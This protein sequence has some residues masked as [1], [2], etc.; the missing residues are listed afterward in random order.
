MV[1]G[2]P[3]EEPKTSV[4]PPKALVKPIVK[5]EPKE[6]EKLFCDDLIIDD[7]EEDEVT[8]EELKRRIVREAEMDEH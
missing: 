1:G 7:E 8:E 5:K 3:R 4:K 2:S 6:K